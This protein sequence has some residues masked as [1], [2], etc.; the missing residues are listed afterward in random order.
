MFPNTP[1]PKAHVGAEGRRGVAWRGE[2]G[3]ASWAPDLHLCRARGAA[4]GTHPRGRAARPGRSGE[5]SFPPSFSLPPVSPP[6]TGTVGKSPSQQPLIK[7]LERGGGGGCA[8]G[9]NVPGALLLTFSVFTESQAGIRFPPPP[10]P[11][12]RGDPEPC[13]ASLELGV[14]VRGRNGPTCRDSQRNLKTG[15]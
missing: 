1:V 10:P 9:T 11:P 12:S 14:A 8:P 6:S 5:A 4:A 2:T 15:G 7:D 3:E 13:A